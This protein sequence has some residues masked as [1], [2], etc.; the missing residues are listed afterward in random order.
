VTLSTVTSQSRPVR[1]TISD[2][3]PGM[4]EDEPITGDES[5]ETQLH[6]SNGVGLWFVA[7]ILDDAGGA[8]EI[9]AGSEPDVGT[10]VTLE[11][12]HP[13]E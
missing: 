7:W 1:L 11:F 12:V 2:N 6:H 5:E 13:G 10:V 3:G 8:L 4:P 9:A